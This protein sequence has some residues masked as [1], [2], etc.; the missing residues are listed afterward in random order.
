MKLIDVLRKEC[1]VAVAQFGD[2]DEAL[3]EIAQLAKQCAILK[4]VDEEDILAG[5]R[6]RESLGSTGFGQGIAIPHCRLKSVTDFLVGIITIPS[7]VEFEA[8]DS[9]PVR[10]II[11]IIAPEAA[12]NRHVKLLSAISQTL[13]VPGAVEEI[14]AETTAE[15]VYE[16]FLRHTRADI[17]TSKQTTKC[18][19]NVFV[20]DETVFLDILEKLAGI[21]TNSLVVVSAETCQRDYSTDR[22]RDW[23][24]EREHRCDGNRPGH[25][26]RCRFVLVRNSKQSYQQKKDHRLKK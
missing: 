3:R 15:A 7:G 23:R 22:E 20:Q 19:F 24:P 4:A 1:V 5:L 9:E 21:E 25:F 10:L 12:S 8:L 11:F 26:L 14:M 2:K 6:E 13:S 17:D 18:Q 16:S